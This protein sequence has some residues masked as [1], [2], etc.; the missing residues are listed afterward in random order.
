MEYDFKTAHTTAPDP[1]DDSPET[2]SE[3]Q[4]KVLNWLG[5]NYI[6]V[7]KSLQ[8]M[9][10]V[11]EG[12]LVVV[13]ANPDLDFVA[14]EMMATCFDSFDVYDRKISTDWVGND[15]W[16]C[17]FLEMA[18]AANKAIRLDSLVNITLS[19]KESVE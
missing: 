14:R 4:R 15:V 1:F 9:S 8:L 17:D 5:C 12:R 13:K 2:A 3:F 16:G 19:L 11:Q 6:T 10:H 7:L 18:R